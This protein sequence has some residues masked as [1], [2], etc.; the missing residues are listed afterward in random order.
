MYENKLEF[1]G[2]RGVQNK[3]PSVGRVWIFSGTAHFLNSRK[4]II[5]KITCFSCLSHHLLLRKIDFQGLDNWHSC[6]RVM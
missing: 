2:G 3:T 6:Y 1:P 4:Y 5:N